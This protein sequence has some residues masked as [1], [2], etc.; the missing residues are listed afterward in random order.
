MLVR[1]PH[2]HPPRC[3]PREAASHSSARGRQPLT[4]QLEGG[5]LSL[6]SSREAASHSSALLLR[7]PEGRGALL[8]CLVTP[9]AAG[10]SCP[11]RPTCGALP[12][13]SLPPVSEERAARIELDALRMPWRSVVGGDVKGP[14]ESPAAAEGS[15]APSPGTAGSSS[16]TSMASCGGT[17]VVIDPG[18]SLP[19][20]DTRTLGV[21]ARE[22]L[23]VPRTGLQGLG[24]GSGVTLLQVLR[25]GVLQVAEMGEAGGWGLCC[26][27][28]CAADGG[29]QWQGR[30]GV[31]RRS[32]AQL[33]PQ[34][35]S[36]ATDMV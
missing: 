12:P 6:L 3:S 19:A 22:R 30:A 9:A 4:P 11:S 34:L 17:G 20:R 16:L 13:A 25:P 35:L 2:P 36:V 5:G 29:A 26:G 18:L 24:Y 10:P 31:H 7:R 32:G 23:S 21:M 1:Q 14:G 8:S 33:R 27:A 28:T 15:A